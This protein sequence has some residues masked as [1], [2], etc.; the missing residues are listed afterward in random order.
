MRTLVTL[1]ACAAMTAPAFAGDVESECNAASEEWGS[2]GDT[3]AQ[4]SC[5]A[6]AAEGDDDLVAEFLEFRSKYSSDVEAYEGA[7]DAAKEV[8]DKCSVES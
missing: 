7:S 5:I 2:T 4:C 1:L 8:M 6:E 3:A